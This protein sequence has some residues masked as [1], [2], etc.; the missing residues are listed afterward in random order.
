M[1]PA[2]LHSGSAFIQVKIILK[3]LRNIYHAAT[4]AISL[5]MVRILHFQHCLYIVDS[6]EHEILNNFQGADGTVPWIPE[7]FS[8]HDFVTSQLMSAGGRS[9]NLWENRLQFTVLDGL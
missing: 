3:S 2:I 8:R 5:S 9:T 7:V 1:L 4:P 6:Y